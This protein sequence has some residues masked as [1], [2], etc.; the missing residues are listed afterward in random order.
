MKSLFFLLHLISTSNTRSVN[1]IYKAEQKIVYG[2]GT[3]P[4]VAI[5]VNIFIL[6]WVV[7]SPFMDYKR[8]EIGKIIEKKNKNWISKL[9]KNPEQMKIVEWMTMSLKSKGEN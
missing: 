1:E 6:D 2:T 9:R 4:P 3:S 7:N 8:E 5:E